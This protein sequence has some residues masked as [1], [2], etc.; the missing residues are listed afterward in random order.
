MQERSN[1]LIKILFSIRVCL[2]IIALISTIYWMY[3][4]FKLY[5]VGISDVHTYAT[6]LRPI[7]YTC[8]IIAVAAI[9][10]SF[11][12]RSIAVKIKK[13]MEA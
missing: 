12:L 2:W 10:L 8:V 11:Y 7:L 9:A 5:L 6:I 4:S 1:K 13:E 3:Y